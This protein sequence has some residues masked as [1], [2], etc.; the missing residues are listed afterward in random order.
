M[1]F[2]VPHDF[3]YLEGLS[4]RYRILDYRHLAFFALVTMALKSTRVGIQGKVVVSSHNQLSTMSTR[5]G[6]MFR[7][8]VLVGSGGSGH[9]RPPKIV[10]VLCSVFTRD[11]D[12]HQEVE[13]NSIT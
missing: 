12:F 7:G 6:I 8:G 10:F 5:G 13:H 11:L 2:V 3:P 4:R 9:G 1:D